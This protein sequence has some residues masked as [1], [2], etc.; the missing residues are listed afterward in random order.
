M[1][2]SWEAPTQEDHPEK[3][4]FKANAKHALSIKIRLKNEI[5]FRR[6]NIIDFLILN[7]ELIILG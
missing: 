6:T 2:S 4:A 3:L 5:S 7:L 1:L